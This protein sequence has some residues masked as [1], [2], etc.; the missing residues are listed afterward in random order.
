MTIVRTMRMTA[1]TAAIGVGMSMS[2]YAAYNEAPGFAAAV[3]AGKLPA[4]EKRLP[5]QPEVVTPVKNVGTYGGAI[6]RG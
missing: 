5:D 1:L 3:K 4:V 2:A 6:R